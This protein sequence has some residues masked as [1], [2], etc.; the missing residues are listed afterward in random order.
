LVCC[1]CSEEEVETLPPFRTLKGVGLIEGPTIVSERKTS[2][3]AGCSGGS[4]GCGGSCI[5]EIEFTMVATQPYLYSPEI[6]IYNCL[7]ITDGA[8]APYT[9]SQIDC[10][11]FDCADPFFAGGTPPTPA[12]ALVF[13]CVTPALPPTATYTNSCLKDFETPMA[14]YF[15]VQRTLWSELEEVIPII[16]ISTGLFPVGPLKLGFYSS[17]NGNPC[18]DLSLYPP[19]CDVICDELNIL[20]IPAN[21]TF[22]IDSRTRKMSLICEDGSAFPG[23]R[24]TAGPWS[25]PSFGCYGFCLEVIYDTSQINTGISAV[26]VKDACI[27]LSLVPRTF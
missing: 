3:G 8:V 18:A 2:G 27:S 11:P 6:P 10:G 7:N 13:D 5:I 14:N 19:D 22:Y 20:L 1:P 9:Q 23:E 26:G 16:S 4:S 12:S 17:P 15:S 25:W 21:S 24:L